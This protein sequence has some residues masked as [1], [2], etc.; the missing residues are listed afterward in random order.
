[1][2]D[3]INTGDYGQFSAA[4]NRVGEL[5]TQLE[6]YKRIFSRTIPIF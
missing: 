6:G 5:N 3:S 4:I 1:M 2:N